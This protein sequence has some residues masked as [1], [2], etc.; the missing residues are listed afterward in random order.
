MTELPARWYT[1]TP[2]NTK[3]RIWSRGNAGEIYPDPITPLS[4]TSVFLTAGELG[5]REVATRVG[6]LHRAAG[7]RVPRH[8]HEGEHDERGPADQRDDSGGAPGG[9]QPATG[10]RSTSW[11]SRSCHRSVS[12]ASSTPTSARNAAARSVPPLT[13]S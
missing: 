5:R 13:S 1:D 11:A 12:S 3:F 8:Q 7:S 10:V 2:P 4:G 9:H 6:R